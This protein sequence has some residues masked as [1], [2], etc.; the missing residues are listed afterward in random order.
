MGRW[1]AARPR[2]ARE[3]CSSWRSTSGRDRNSCRRSPAHRT[4]SEFSFRMH[5]VEQPQNHR[6]GNFRLTFDGFRIDV[7]PQNISIWLAA[8][9]TGRLFLRWLGRGEQQGEVRPSVIQAGPG[10]TAAPSIVHGLLRSVRIF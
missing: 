7:V 6:F 1:I 3:C 2:S 8:R 9:I 4:L 5:Q 10:Q